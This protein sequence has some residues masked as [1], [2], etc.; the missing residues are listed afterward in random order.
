MTAE[1]QMTTN[2]LPSTMSFTDIESHQHS[3]MSLV[4]D[5]FIDHRVGKMLI[6]TFCYFERTDFPDLSVLI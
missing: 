3:A 1:G 6:C 4:Q 2:D 5:A